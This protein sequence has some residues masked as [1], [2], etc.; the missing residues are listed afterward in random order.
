MKVLRYCDTSH[1]AYNHAVK[2]LLRLVTL[3]V[4]AKVG[5]DVMKAGRGILDSDNL[6][7]EGFLDNMT[8]AAKVE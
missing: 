8:S 7:I 2:R 1:R 4:E 5:K 3:D 6:A